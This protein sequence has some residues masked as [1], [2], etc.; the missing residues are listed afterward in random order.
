MIYLTS[1]PLIKIK[2]LSHFALCGQLDE[3]LY[4]DLKDSQFGAPGTWRLAKC[5]E[6]RCGLIWVNT[7]PLAKDIGSAYENYYT[8]NNQLIEEFTCFLK[9]TYDTIKRSY[10]FPI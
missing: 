8:H 2:I 1:S 10:F 4:T 6:R 5:F 9:H 3:P 7:M